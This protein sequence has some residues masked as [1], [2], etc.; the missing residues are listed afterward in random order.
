[1]QLLLYVMLFMKLHKCVCVCVHTF[2]TVFQYVLN[3]LHRAAFITFHKPQIRS[4]IIG[5]I[6]NII[7]LY[8]NNSNFFCANI[9]EKI[10]LTG[11]TKPGD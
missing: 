10:K 11:A 4:F 3:D 6:L 8:N 9:L 1:M 7:L 2:L 5:K